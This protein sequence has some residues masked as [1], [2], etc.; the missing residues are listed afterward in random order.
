[1]VGHGIVEAVFIYGFGIPLIIGLLWSV[2]Y[3]ASG[4]AAMYAPQQLDENGES[5]ERAMMERTI[6]VP[7]LPRLEEGARW[8]DL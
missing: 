7:E 6:P 3:Q 1:M 8:L 2:W 4:R 5:W